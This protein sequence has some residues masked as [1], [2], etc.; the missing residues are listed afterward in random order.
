LID[1]LIVGQGLAG[2]LLAWRL[3]K[4]GFSIKI[5]DAVEFFNNDIP[6]SNDKHPFQSASW[7]ST[8]LINPITGRRFVKSWLMDD[9]LPIAE[10]TYSEI[11]KELNVALYEQTPIFRTFPNQRAANDWELRK[12]ENEY[13]NYVADED[14]ILNTNYFQIEEKGMTVKCSGRLNV[15]QTIITLRKYFLAQNCFI[16]GRLQYDTI[17]FIE[18]KVESTIIKNDED[19]ISLQ[20]SKIIFC[21]GA[22]AK[23]N[24]YFNVLPYTSCVGQILVIQSTELQLDRVVKLGLFIIPLGENLFQIGTTWDWDID[25]PFL[26]STA[27]EKMINQLQKILKVD[28]EL[29]EH[30]AAVRPTI[31]DRR[32]IMGTHPQHKQ[33]YIFNAFGA[34][35]ASL[36]PYFSQHFIDNLLNQKELMK[37][38]SLQRFYSYY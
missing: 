19:E 29:V 12:T 6:I 32:P 3:L 8:G 2:S 23:N 4:Q 26:S 27:K 38:V 31:K 21:E 24:P 17:N 25:E 22:K 20:A 14:Y 37:E 11:E 18:E 10:Q 7:V 16:N 34:K 5:I 36:I 35:G 15:R 33:L 30:Q 9:I 13:K 28:F 1:F